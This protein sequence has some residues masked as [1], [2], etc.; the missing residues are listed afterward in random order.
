MLFAEG[1]ESTSITVSEHTMG[2]SSSRRTTTRTYSETNIFLSEDLSHLLQK[3]VRSNLLDEVTIEIL[4]QNKEIPFELKLPGD[5]SLLSSYKGK[6]ANITYALEATVDI[7]KKLDVN[8]EECFSVFNYN[9]N[10]VVIH[11]SEKSSFEEDGGSSLT[12]PTTSTIEN[13]SNFSTS[14]SETN[15][16]EGVNKESYTAR[17]ERLFGKN[18][19]RSTTSDSHSP[20]DRIIFSRKPL[21]FDPKSLFAK[22]REHF[23][24]E[25]SAKI[26]LLNHENNNNRQYSPGHIVIGNVRLLS[27]QGQ[28]K[29]EKQTIKGMEIALIGVEHAY[30]HGHQR[31]STTEKYEK[32][33]KLTENGINNDNAIPFEFQIP[34]GL[35][36]SYIGKYSEHF[37][38]LEAKLN[39]AWS[40][41]INARTIIEIV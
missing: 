34:D 18:S 7:A 1:K 5:D 27:P 11:N 38:G 39:I 16:E 25:N 15:E 30:A 21:N 4:P 17:F 32:K 12:I 8:K 36:Q 22:N 14:P 23:L 2:S 41:D 40:S 19:Y 29:E 33:I 24:K 26:D 6:N 13:E 20:F 35:N 3:S 10:G 28:E 31:V 37:W 9:N